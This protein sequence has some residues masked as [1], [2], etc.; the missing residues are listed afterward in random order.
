[1]TSRELDT[2]TDEDMGVLSL[3]HGVEATVPGADTA[4][5][6]CHAVCDIDAARLDLKH[7]SRPSH[8]KIYGLDSTIAPFGRHQ[9]RKRLLLHVVFVARRPLFIAPRGLD[10]DRRHLVVIRKGKGSHWI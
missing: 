3:L 1:M 4:C 8:S 9:K 2:P 10:P 6:C 7:L 5:A